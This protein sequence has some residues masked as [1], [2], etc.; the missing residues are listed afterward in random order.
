MRGQDSLCSRVGLASKC[1][2]DHVLTRA[3]F[4]DPN[5]KSQLS[6]ISAASSTPRPPRTLC[7]GKLG[8]QVQQRRMVLPF[9]TRLDG[10]GRLQGCPAFPIINK[11]C[12]NFFQF[13]WKELLLDVFPCILCH[14]VISAPKEKL[15][16]TTQ[17]LEK[18]KTQ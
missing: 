11:A 16:A 13:D 4:A 1:K 14:R 12:F 18:L 6:Y 15:F 7:E 9:D 2:V 5:P 8:F 3:P 17:R 10:A